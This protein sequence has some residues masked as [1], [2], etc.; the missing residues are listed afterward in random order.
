MSCK[1]SILMTAYNHESFIA[2]AVQ[3]VI[4]Q[5]TDFDFE[6]VVGEDCSTDKT[7]EI[8]SGFKSSHP[9]RIRLLLRERNWG[10][11]RNFIDVL[12]AC[13]GEYV[14]IL[15]G[16]DYW[17]SPNKLQRQ[18]DFLDSHPDCSICFHPVM[19][20]FEDKNQ[21]PY[22]SGVASKGQVFTLADL[23]DRNLI[24][25]CSVM[26]RNKLLP[27][28]PDWFHHTP[29][30]D[31]PLHIL[32]AQFGDIGYLDYVMAAHRI[33]PNSIWSPR[34][35]ISKNKAKIATL[36]TVRT[37]LGSSYYRE[38]DDSIARWHLRVM[39]ALARAHHYREALKYSSN[40]LFHEHIPFGSLC[41]AVLWASHRQTRRR[42]SYGQET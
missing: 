5:T 42:D 33:H 16:D 18:A 28:L 21:E 6:L 41:R 19:V 26:F 8:L 1:V 15:E 30:G 4:E 17:T 40:L 32:N 36:K 35:L 34:S 11:R 7:R 9:E 14:A 10:R 39:V 29:T 31:W 37:H 27:V 25:T 24:P 13:E 38:I 20:V 22:R 2:Q 12:A 3:S 23:L